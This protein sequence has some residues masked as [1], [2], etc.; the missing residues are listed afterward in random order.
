MENESTD[1]TKD[2]L[3]P[4]QRRFVEEYLIDLNATQACIRAGYSKKTAGKIST[5]LLGKTWVRAE[6]DAAMRARSIRTHITQDRVLREFWMVAIADP[7]ELIEYRRTC[8]R[9]CHGAGNR[10]QRTQGELERARAEWQAASGEGAPPF[11]VMG[12]DGYDATKPPN[13]S[14]RECAGEGVGEVFVK[15]TRFLSESAKR[16]YAGIKVAKGGGLEVKL[17]DQMAA[18]NAVARHLNMFKEQHELRGEM[19]V[20]SGGKPLDSIGDTV[21]RFAAAAQS[22]LDRNGVGLPS[23]NGHSEFLDPAGGSRPAHE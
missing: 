16:L 5:Q 11:D 20:T 10:Y 19:D 17:N 15:D 2:D 13:P 3:T 1:T 8:C 6:I 22:V 9:Y 4:K 23:S 7:N 18:L 14:C 21:L 12:G